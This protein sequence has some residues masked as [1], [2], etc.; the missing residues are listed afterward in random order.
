MN[1]HRIPHPDP[2]SKEPN[3]VYASLLVVIGIGDDTPIGG[4]INYDSATGTWKLDLELQAAQRFSEEEE[5][6]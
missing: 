1:A 6:V 4:A 5:E 2:G 3:E